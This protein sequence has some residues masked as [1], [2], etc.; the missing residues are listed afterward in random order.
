MAKTAYFPRHLILA[1]AMIFGVLLALG[2]HI[3]IQRFDL[4][5]GDLWRTDTAELIPA[6]AAIAW[7]LIASVAF[8]GGYA[9]ATLL[10]SAVSGQIPVR[11]R[12]LLIL[13]GVVMLAAAGQAASAPNAIPTMS[14]AERIGRASAEGA[15]ARVLT[16][17]VALCLGGAMA[18]C[19]AHF[20][21]RRA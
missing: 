19:G 18:F 15:L 2:I 13:T 20:A 10:D 4:Y 1:G 11:L 21:L 3:L 6:R 17:V 12:Q 8:V 9:T 5:L 16:G 7:W 14:G